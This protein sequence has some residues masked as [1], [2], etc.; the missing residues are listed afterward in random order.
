MAH[1][2]TLK[3]VP[4]PWGPDAERWLSQALAGATLDELR[5]QVEHD[6]ARVF[7]VVDGDV[8]VGAFLLRVDHFRDGSEG[9][10]VAAAAQR[11]GIDMVATCMPAIESLFQDVRSIRFHTRRPAVARKLSSLGYAAAEIVCFKEVAH[12]Q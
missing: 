3:I 4:A 2:Q 10:I 5:D 12:G 6:G 8:C 11:A 1:E 7:L 9:V